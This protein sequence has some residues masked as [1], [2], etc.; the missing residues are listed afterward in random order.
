MG[1]YVFEMVEEFRYPGM[2]MNGLNMVVDF[3]TSL[4]QEFEL[5]I[6]K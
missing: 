1:S 2:V 3:L 6:S 5:K 4:I